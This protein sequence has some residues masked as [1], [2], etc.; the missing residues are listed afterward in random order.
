MHV[1]PK[2]RKLKGVEFVVWESDTLSAARQA[3]VTQHVH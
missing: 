3:R 1:E 2:S